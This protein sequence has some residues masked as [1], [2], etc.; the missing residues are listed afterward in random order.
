MAEEQELTPEEKLLQVIQDGDNPGAGLLGDDEDASSAA[1]GAEPSE[2]GGSRV[3]FRLFNIIFVLITLVALGLSGYEVYRNLPQPEE[4]YEPAELDLSVAGIVTNVVPM[5]D[6]LDMFAD[7]RIFGRPPD[8]PGGGDGGDGPAPITGWRAYVRDN[9]EFKGRST[10]MRQ[11]DDGR[12]ENVL[13]AIIMD[14]KAQKMHFL[15]V[16]KKVRV[17]DKTVRVD[18]IGLKTVTFSYGKDHVEIGVPNK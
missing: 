10:V 8:R 16:G 4:H 6:V 18:K 12:S 17:L 3:G 13:E 11:R 7:R 14:T 15:S 9:F 2:V 1:V 5:S